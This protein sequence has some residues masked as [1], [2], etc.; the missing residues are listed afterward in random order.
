[1]TLPSLI[2]FVRALALPLAL[3]AALACADVRAATEAGTVIRNRADIAW[4][5]ADTGET[6][7]ARARTRRR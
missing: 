7:R 2:P 6:L 4:T 5:D 1:M 3:G